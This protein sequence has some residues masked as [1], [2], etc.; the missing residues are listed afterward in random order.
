MAAGRTQG[1][2]EVQKNQPAQ[3]G[4]FGC[5]GAVPQTCVV[6][7]AAAPAGGTGAT[8]GAYDTAAHRDSLILLV[9]NIHAALIANGIIKIA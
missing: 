9:N 6:V 5:N 8:A 3:V 4:E 7:G 2:V 1:T